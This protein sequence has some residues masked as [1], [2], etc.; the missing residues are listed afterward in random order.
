MPRLI[1]VFAGRTLILLVLSCRG[2]YDMLDAETRNWI[3]A[4]KS[5]YEDALSSLCAS[6]NCLVYCVPDV[7]EDSDQPAH[8]IR[9]FTVRFMDSKGHK[10][11]LC[12]QRRLSTDWADLGNVCSSESSLGTRS[13]CRFCRAQSQIKRDKTSPW[14]LHQVH[15]PCVFLCYT[16]R[17]LKTK[18]YVIMHITTCDE[19]QI[20]PYSFLSQSITN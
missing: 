19:N 10:E 16:S 18:L 12:G 9:F 13:F 17:H 11:S 20:C 4:A 14:Y 3:F 7:S 2:S 1:W 15:R 8:L 5:I 6:L